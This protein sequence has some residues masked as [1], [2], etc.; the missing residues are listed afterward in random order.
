MKPGKLGNPGKQVKPGKP[1]KQG[2][3]GIPGKPWTLEKPGKP[4][5]P[6]NQGYLKG[7]QG[8]Q[9][10]NVLFSQNKLIIFRRAFLL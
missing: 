3:P 1:G 8:R 4:R 7:N 5:K 9:F 6:Q 2:K 10:D